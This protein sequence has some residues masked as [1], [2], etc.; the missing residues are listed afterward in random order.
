MLRGFEASIQAFESESITGEQSNKSWLYRSM[1]TL[2]GTTIAYKIKS[3]KGYDLICI[4]KGLYIIMKNNDWVMKFKAL[5]DASALRVY[6][7]YICRMYYYFI[8]GG[9]CLTMILELL[10]KS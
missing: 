10:V 6:K 1:Q 8:G 5:H 7:S 4:T 9:I 2:S 3:Q